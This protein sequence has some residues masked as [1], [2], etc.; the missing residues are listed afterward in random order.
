MMYYKSM[1]AAVAGAI[2][3]SGVAPA[4]ADSQLIASAGLTVEQAG[5]MT[6]TEI[7]QHKFNRDESSADRWNPSI[8]A[9]TGTVDHTQLAASAGIASEATHDYSLTELAAAKFNND[10]RAD[11][12]QTITRRESV[13]VATRSVDGASNARAQLIASAGLTPAEAKGMSL[14]E[15]A[16]YKFDRDVSGAD[17]Q[18]AN[19]K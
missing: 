14:S 2:A 18:T 12:R 7:A 8:P 10:T 5:G 15:I 6:L 13:I 16:Q 3:L 17:R 11:D 4:L 1:I 9:V 19:V